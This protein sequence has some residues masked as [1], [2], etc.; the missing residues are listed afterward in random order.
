MKPLADSA[1]PVGL[2]VL[3]V[4]DDEAI[5]ELW[6]AVLSR[7]P[8][9]CATHVNNGTEAIRLAHQ[10]HPDVVLMDLA[11]PGI[12]GLTATRQLKADPMTAR[13]PVIAVTGST[14][15]GEEARAAGCDGFLTKPLE[16]EALVRE[17][18]AVLR[19]DA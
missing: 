18:S 8:G 9:V 3:I 2:M 6:A 7:T 10:L 12:D 17:I 15:A 16:P 19:R 1:L 5:A 13:V 4:D 14:Y 11:M